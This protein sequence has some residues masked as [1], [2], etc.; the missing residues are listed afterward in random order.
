M[1]CVLLAV[2]ALVLLIVRLRATSLVIR[3]DGNSM[4]PALADGD[5]L[6]ARRAPP[7]RPAPAGT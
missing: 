1:R 7:A 3:V 6:V 2:A 4:V 5:R